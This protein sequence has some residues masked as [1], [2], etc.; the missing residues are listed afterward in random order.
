[1]SLTREQLLTHV[2]P[3]LQST[4]RPSSPTKST[5]R[6]RWR[7]IREWT[8][9]VA[10]TQEYWDGLD[11]AEKNQVIQEAPLTYWDV[12]DAALVA[13][14][15]SVSREGHLLTPFTF[16]YSV[17]HNHAIPGARDDHASISTRIPDTTIG[18][19]DACFEYDDNIGGIIE[20]KTFWNLTNESVVQVIQGSSLPSYRLF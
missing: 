17:P 5:Y 3:P 1:M 14:M 7:E 10:E 16:K 9:F 20:V 4:T 11:D 2:H 8:Y 15:P 19:P 18:Q 13:A 12:L 6:L